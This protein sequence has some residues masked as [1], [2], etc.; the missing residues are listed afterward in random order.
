MAIRGIL[1]RLARDVTQEMARRDA[2]VLAPHADDDV[3][4]CGGAIALK[5]A[6]GR[7]VRIVYLTD[8][9][10]G[11]PDRPAEAA[12]IREREAREGARRLGVDASSL[13]F[14]G[15]PDGKLSDH[16]EVAAA[17][18]R[19]LLA[20]AGSVDVFAPFE[21]EFHADH[22]AASAIA[23]RARPAGARHFEVLIWFGPWIWRRLGARARAASAF[24]VARPGALR[25][26]RTDDLAARKRH[27]MAAH[28]SQM[29]A[30]ARVDWGPAFVDALCGPV[31]IYMERS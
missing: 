7:E 31:E 19:P 18:L 20:S 22:G 8:G 2:V 15:Y 6:H 24:H 11:V 12:A 23:R 13:F 14:L 1:E 21:H 29:A 5:R 4:G 9:A 10:A 27:A 26:L 28:E 3:L 30:F 25:K 16:V 17:R